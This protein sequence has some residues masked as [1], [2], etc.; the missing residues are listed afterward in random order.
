MD[1]LSSAD[2]VPRDFTGLCQAGQQRVSQGRRPSDTWEA[3]S[4]N[5]TPLDFFI[6]MG[7]MR[8]RGGD[9]AWKT[10]YQVELIPQ[11]ACFNSLWLRLPITKRNSVSS[12]TS[13]LAVTLH[14]TK[15]SLNVGFPTLLSCCQ[16]V[17]N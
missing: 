12:S 4:S 5:L 15:P 13:G 3:T 10:Y 9:S 16:P 11:R 2:I 6:T 14:R 8:K 1:R 7:T 17:Q